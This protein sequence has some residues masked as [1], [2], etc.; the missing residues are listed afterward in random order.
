[1]WGGVGGDSGDPQLSHSSLLPEWGGVKVENWPLHL[2]YLS[3]CGGVG[4]LI[5]IHNP[6]LKREGVG[7]LCHDVENQLNNFNE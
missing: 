1:V 7:E 5:H 2:H 3:L 6:Y 4:V